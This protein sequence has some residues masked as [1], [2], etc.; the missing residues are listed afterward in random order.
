[1][2]ELEDPY[3]GALEQEAL[4]ILVKLIRR[5]FIFVKSLHPFLRALKSHTPYYHYK[6]FPSYFPLRG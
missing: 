5:P 1:M 6:N 3:S 2:L 4:K